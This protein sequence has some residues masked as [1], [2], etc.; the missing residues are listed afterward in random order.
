MDRFR[1]TLFTAKLPFG[2]YWSWF[3][4]I[5]SSNWIARTIQQCMIFCVL[6]GMHT[7]THTAHMAGVPQTWLH[8]DLF[9]SGI[10]YH[11]CR[12]SKKAWREGYT[13]A[14]SVRIVLHTLSGLSFRYR[15]VEILK[16]SQLRT[17]Q[18]CVRSTASGDQLEHV[19]GTVQISWNF[20]TWYHLNH[21]RITDEIHCYLIPP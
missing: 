2:R 18:F 1:A 21:V 5:Q 20:I 9:A 13:G 10:L 7:D 14:I 17:A 16:N 19:I 4:S 15:P 3:C 11:D 6:S 12:Q 8:L